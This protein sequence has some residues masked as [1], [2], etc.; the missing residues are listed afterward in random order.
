MQNPRPRRFPARKCAS[1]FLAAVYAFT[2]VFAVHAAEKS[3]WQ[4]RRSARAPKPAALLAQA[5]LSF[6]ALP[7]VGSALAP[8]D[9]V[10][11]ELGKYPL[12]FDLVSAVIPFATVREA[13]KG[14]QGAPLDLRL[15]DLHT[16]DEAHK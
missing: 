1:A 14:L 11:A 8:A 7:P 6:P 13:S 15:Q 5:P 9:A 16:D 10:A 12:T 3:F 2:N 4:D